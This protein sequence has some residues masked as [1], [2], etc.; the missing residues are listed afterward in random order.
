MRKFL[1]IILLCLVTISVSSENL[2]QLPFSEENLISEL[3]RTEILYKDIFLAQSILETGHYTSE[4]FK[5]GN[6]LV[7]MKKAGK[8]ETTAI[9]TYKGYAKYS[10]WSESLKDYNLWQKYFSHKFKSRE[11]FLAFLDRHYSKDGSYAK[12]LLSILKKNKTLLVHLD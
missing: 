8:R 3:N 7:G 9:G 6:N 12:R 1:F 11:Q 10:S 5:H 4:V 2:T